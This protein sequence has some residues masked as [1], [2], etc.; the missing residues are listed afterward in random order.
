MDLHIFSF[1]LSFV[2]LVLVITTLIFL[3]LKK[4]FYACKYKKVKRQQ[5]DT[6]ESF[7]FDLQGENNRVHTPVPFNEESV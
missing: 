4:V 7:Q 1:W 6:A 3:S 5:T 2:L